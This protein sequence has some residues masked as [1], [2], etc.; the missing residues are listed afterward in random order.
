MTDIITNP[1][2]TKASMPAPA[3][4]VHELAKLDSLLREQSAS[5]AA[6]EQELRELV[7]KSGAADALENIDAINSGMIR[8]TTKLEIYD[9][10]VAGA[11]QRIT[12]LA[13][14]VAEDVE[15][16]AGT[17]EAGLRES[18]ATVKRGEEAVLAEF[19]DAAQLPIVVTRTR[20]FRA[21]TA[22][23]ISHS[24]GTAGL[25]YVIGPSGTAVLSADVTAQQLV[26]AHRR[27]VEIAAAVNA[28]LAEVKSRRA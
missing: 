28:H 10:A 20:V 23:Q 2:K 7:G 1:P 19:F 13:P 25:A 17:I 9:R 18:L 22:F 14:I 5:Y 4:A 16:I 21:E 15:R 8:L 12:D 6:G 27:A 11:R 24:F 3:D 26:N